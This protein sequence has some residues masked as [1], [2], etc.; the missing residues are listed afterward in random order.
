MLRTLENNQKFFT[1]PLWSSTMWKKYLDISH[2]AFSP[3]PN[4]RI[5]S[6]EQP[7]DL[8][9][10]RA[11]LLS[12]FKLWARNFF[13][14]SEW[15]EYRYYLS[16][17]RKNGPSTLSNHNSSQSHLRDRKIIFSMYL[18][19]IYPN[20]KQAGFLLSKDVVN[21]RFSNVKCSLSS[22][23]ICSLTL[24]G[25]KR[26]WL[27]TISNNQTVNSICSPPKNDKTLHGGARVSG[28]I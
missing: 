4:V 26:L 20:G 11:Q 25:P 1:P 14:K 6:K 23:Q 13:L 22:V 19:G 8:K 3:M 16:Q 18:K 17:Y 21:R 24:R 5:K 27:S 15:G 28:S 10:N 7:L 2:S 12:T 9:T